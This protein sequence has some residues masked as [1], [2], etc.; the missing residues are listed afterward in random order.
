MLKTLRAVTPT[1][2][3]NYNTLIYYHKKREQ[4]KENSNTPYTYIY[5]V[6]IKCITFSS[7]Y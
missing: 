6:Y 3:L 4:D 1:T 7:F 5:Y 2:Q